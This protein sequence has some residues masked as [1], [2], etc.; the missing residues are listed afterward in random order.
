MESPF[1]FILILNIIPLK[2]KIKSKRELH[3]ADNM[4]K[5]LSELAVWLRRRVLK[6]F[7]DMHAGSKSDFK[8]Y[9]TSFELI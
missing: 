1:S 9:P 4:S 7:Q 5:N 2:R 6:K 8:G 3:F